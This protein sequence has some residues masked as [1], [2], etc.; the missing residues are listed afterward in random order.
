MH[1]DSNE[2]NPVFKDF[3]LNYKFKVENNRYVP[4]TFSS[5]DEYDNNKFLNVY[6]FLT[7]ILDHE[8]RRYR[9]IYSIFNKK[10]YSFTFDENFNIKLKQKS[11]FLKLQDEIISVFEKSLLRNF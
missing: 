10:S 1:E 2:I 9:V 6:R 3:V 4:I 5:V 7:I 11:K 8:Y